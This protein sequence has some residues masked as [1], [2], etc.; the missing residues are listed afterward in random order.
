LNQPE[1]APIETE[2]VYNSCLGTGNCL[3]GHDLVTIASEYLK[4]KDNFFWVL[5]APL[6][7]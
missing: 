1:D 2:A 3:I 6:H 4:K 7:F 5:V